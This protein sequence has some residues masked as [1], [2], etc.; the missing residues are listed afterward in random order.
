M[1]FRTTLSAIKNNWK[2]WR[3]KRK[4]VV[5]ESDDWGS[6]RMP[7]KEVFNAL[8]Q[9]GI[10]VNKC[11]F[12]RLDSVADANDLK[13]LFD[14]LT[15]IKDGSG[16]SLQITANTIVANP[17]FKK[18]RESNF[19]EYFFEDFQ[20]SIERIYPGGRIPELWNE[21]IRQELFFPQLHGREH[22]NY[23]RWLTD[24]QNK[25]Q[26]ALIA[27][28]HNVYGVSKSIAKKNRHSYLASFDFDEKKQE[29]EALQTIT[30]SVSMFQSSFGYSS[31]SF[32]APN[33]VWSEEIE[34]ALAENHISYIQS[35]KSQLLPI[36][37]RKKGNGYL[38]HFTGQ[39]NANN[40]LYLVR[41]CMF[42]PSITG[43]ERALN[44]C[45]A[46]IKI[47]F[48]TGKP[49]IISSHRLNYI[50]ALVE[51]NRIQNLAALRNLF[52]VI[53][54]KW[55]EVEFLNSPK[56]GETIANEY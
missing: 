42:E 6:V 43:V 45:I 36:Y 4:I 11:P 3:T 32:I 15:S 8:L 26:E 48:M 30:D 44:D 21:G 18:I 9:E 53:K 19:K 29:L 40:Q 17:D 31:T 56:L 35:S 52:S 50:G 47:A 49:A 22:V 2:G 7:S 38:K 37:S 41:N 20:T 13:Y 14:T 16:R 34:K 27:F 24:L 5:L 25:D 10:S 55:P 1:K 39:V 51:N 46:Q 23:N 12:M 54:E 28:E 33:Y